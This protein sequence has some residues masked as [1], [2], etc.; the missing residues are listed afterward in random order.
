[1][2]PVW[3]CLGL[4]KRGESVLLHAMDDAVDTV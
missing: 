4:V 2:I 1:M 3:V